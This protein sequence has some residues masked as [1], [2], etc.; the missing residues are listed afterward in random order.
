M[1]VG[2]RIHCRRQ[3]LNTKYYIM[4]Q[5][6]VEHKIKTAMINILMVLH[7]VGVRMV[8]AGAIMRL[9]GVPDEHAQNYDDTMFEITDN[10]QSL[11]ADT[12][13]TLLGQRDAN[14]TLH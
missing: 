6:P 4:E 2:Q 11:D 5:D 13:D 12:M 7:E 9:F 1:P 8:S 3:T 14:I 10:I